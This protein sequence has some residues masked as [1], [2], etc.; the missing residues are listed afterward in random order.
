MIVFGVERL[1]VERLERVVCLKLWSKHLVRRAE[2]VE[3]LLGA[4]LSD[5]EVARGLLDLGLG[6]YRSMSAFDPLFERTS[7]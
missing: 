2:D 4:L 6:R 3:D 1:V 7:A 5:A